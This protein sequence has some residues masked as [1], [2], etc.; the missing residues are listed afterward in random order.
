MKKS[1]F[2]FGLLVLAV[3]KLS[4]QDNDLTSKS[5]F[6]VGLWYRLS[7]NGELTDST[8]NN[9][10]LALVSSINKNTNGF[11]FSLFNIVRSS[12]KGVQVGLYNEAQALS[13]LQ[14]GGFNNAKV[15]RGMQIG[16]GNGTMSGNGVQIGFF[17]GAEA[18]SGVQVGFINESKKIS[19]VQIGIA[20]SAEHNDFPIGLVN[21]IKD[22]EM[23]VGLTVDDMAVTLAS[24]RSGGKYLYGIVGLGYNFDSP[25]HHMV[26][27]GGLGLHI[28][29][30]GKFR[31]NTELIADM[32]S[33]TNIKVNWGGEKDD[34]DD[35]YD[36]KEAYRYAIRFMPSYKISR[37]IEVFGGPSIN[38]LTTRSLDNEA[39]FPTHRI[40]KK[41]DS[42]SLKQIYWGWTFGLQYK[43]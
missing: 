25:H 9:V 35:D 20:N 6:N 40:W 18:T 26:L 10:S 34:K 43:L 13:G 29:F 41:F 32:M 22:G 37:K 23:A 36:Y 15:M 31:F 5:F 17:N 28:P 19:G 7:T 39:L 27:E 2:I 33:K 1:C 30:S 4:A 21:I 11:S 8:T 16:V 14:L 42:S 3:I 38:Y 12:M 24:F